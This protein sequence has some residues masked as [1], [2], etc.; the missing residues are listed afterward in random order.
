VPSGWEQLIYPVKAVL[1]S[2]RLKVSVLQLFTLQSTQSK[3]K[4]AD[5]MGRS[6]QY[7]GR[8]LGDKGGNIFDR[9]VGLFRNELGAGAL[10]TQLYSSGSERCGSIFLVSLLEYVM[11]AES[12]SKYVW[13][14][15]CFE[16]R[17]VAF[18]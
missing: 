11:P 14:L 7:L 12:C 10:Y 6:V 16:F 3:E 1:P 2:L 5:I 4:T 17:L 13:H 8:R 18:L 15:D 9:I